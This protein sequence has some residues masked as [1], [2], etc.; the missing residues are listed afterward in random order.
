MIINLILLSAL[1]LSFLQIMKEQVDNWNCWV[2]VWYRAILCTHTDDERKY[3]MVMSGLDTLSISDD[4]SNSI[5]K[6]EEVC[7]IVELLSLVMECIEVVLLHLY[8]ESV[9]MN[10]WLH[11]KECAQRW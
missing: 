4:E 3:R 8:R 10:K 11:E 1:I 9:K 7:Y 6:A 5:T 2:I